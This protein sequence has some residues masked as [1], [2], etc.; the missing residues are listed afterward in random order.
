MKTKLQNSITLETIIDTLNNHELSEARLM[1]A[2]FVGAKIAIKG[3]VEKVANRQD[4]LRFVIQT[5]ANG[6]EMMVFANFDSDE[7][8]A[9]VK[10][11]K[12]KK[13]VN[14]SITGLFQTVGTEAIVLSD[15]SL[16]E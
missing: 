14:V 3:L 13:D 4:L 2:E 9:K 1:L 8:R 5:T 10:E 7:S 16:A 6:R 15:C 11:R 12:I